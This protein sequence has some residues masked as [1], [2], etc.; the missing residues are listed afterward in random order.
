[1][2]KENIKNDLR[3][4]F[5]SLI[6]LRA[7][8]VEKTKS[9]YPSVFLTY[10]AVTKNETD[11]VESI[12]DETGCTALIRGT[13]GIYNDV[14]HNDYY[15]NRKDTTTA[16]N[17]G[18]VS[19][20]WLQDGY[21]YGKSRVGRE[22][23]I[24]DQKGNIVG[25]SYASAWLTLAKQKVMRDGGDVEDFIPENIYQEFFVG[26]NV[27]PY[28]NV[29][30]EMRYAN[31]AQENKTRMDGILE[32]NKWDLVRVSFLMDS[33]AGQQDSGFTDFEVRSENKEN[34]INMKNETIKALIRCLCEAK[35]GDLVM[36]NDSSIAFELVKANEDNTYDI[37]AVESGEVINVTHE[38]AVNYD[39]VDDVVQNP[40]TTEVV[41]S[42]IRMCQQCQANK[43]IKP[44]ARMSGPE[45][46][47]GNGTGFGGQIEDVKPAKE[48]TIADVMVKLDKIL[49]MLE[50]MSVRSV[51]TE[52]T[53]EEIAKVLEG[54][55]VKAD[56]EEVKE[57]ASEE[58]K[59]PPSEGEEVAVV[60]EMDNAVRSIGNFQKTIFKTEPNLGFVLP[61]LIKKN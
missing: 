26:K 5:D 6:G 45:D 49:G 12:I 52:T 59:V 24:V 57:V 17:A 22:H 34:I 19:E 51:R 37:R 11:R 36:R 50:D 1:M 61:K 43:M 7:V 39:L 10:K 8:E 31:Y 41:R 55:E 33:I 28:K 4:E 20:V 38:Q 30:V 16:K 46:M 58:I 3:V 32:I 15:S 40:E 44:V 47:A 27:L 29:S 48:D 25:S 2:V 13:Y 56:V 18:D 35:V 14:E 21:L 42:Y 23:N 54:E 60:A 53:P 9:K